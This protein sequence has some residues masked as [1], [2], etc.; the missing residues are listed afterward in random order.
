M[1]RTLLLAGLLDDRET[2]ELPIL[3]DQSGHVRIGKQDRALSPG[4]L[5]QLQSLIIS[6][7]KIK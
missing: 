7:A 2:N 6:H 5:E 4:E 1:L 3:V